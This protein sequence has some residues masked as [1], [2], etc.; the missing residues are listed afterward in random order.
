VVRFASTI[1]YSQRTSIPRRPRAF[2]RQGGVLDALAADQTCARQDGDLEAFAKNA[3]YKIVGVWKETA[4]T[5][6]SYRMLSYQ[7]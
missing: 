2:I 5:E 4:I 1:R 6:K 3:G 7:K